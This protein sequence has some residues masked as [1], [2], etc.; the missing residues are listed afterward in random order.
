MLFI[1][2]F[3]FRTQKVMLSW[4]QI[5][6]FPRYQFGPRADQDQLFQLFLL[7]SDFLWVYAA[8]VVSVWKKLHF[9]AIWY[10]L[11]VHFPK[12]QDCVKLQHILLSKSRLDQLKQVIMPE[13]RFCRCLISYFSKGVGAYSHILQAN[14]N[15]VQGKIDIDHVEVLMN[16]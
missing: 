15:L 5:C 2:N 1:T 6:W 16:L 12:F 9:L 11:N 14:S 13:L 8:P 4:C 7:Q 10:H 3:Q